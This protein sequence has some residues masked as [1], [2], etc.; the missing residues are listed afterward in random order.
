MGLTSGAVDTVGGGE[1][2][3][4]LTSILVS[5]ESIESD[6]RGVAGVSNEEVRFMTL[7]MRDRML[8][9]FSFEVEIEAVSESRSDEFFFTAGGVVG[10]GVAG[11]GGELDVDLMLA[12]EGTS[13]EGVRFMAFPM[14]DHLPCL[15]GLLFMVVVFYVK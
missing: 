9:F 1:R 12:F 5:I 11:G 4:G 10:G 3:S 2:T 13:I 14:R 15:G 6:E 7:P 8:P